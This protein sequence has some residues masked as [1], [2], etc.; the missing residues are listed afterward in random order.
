M[1]WES[2]SQVNLEE[3]IVKS[4]SAQTVDETPL[5]VVE[6]QWGQQ[7]VRLTAS[8]CLVLP[9]NAPVTS[10]HIVAFQAD[11]ILVVR[12]R[13]GQFGFPGGRLEIGETL[14]EAMHREV[15]EEACAYLEPEFQLFAVLKIECTERLP[16][17]EYPHDFS[18]M[19]M[20]VGRLRALDPIRSDPAGII[21][22]RDLF[23]RM[24]CENRLDQHDRI[25]LR[26][27]ME[28]LKTIP[29]GMRRLRAFLGT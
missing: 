23:R 3:T 27:A 26:E 5:F 19:G 9:D 25:L 28:V 4:Q 15:Y 24:D 2:R 1:S 21:T 29:N 14:E 11:R 12:D 22:A 17:R 8:R 16:N 18:Y 20:Y 6:M 13:K 7:P 10:V